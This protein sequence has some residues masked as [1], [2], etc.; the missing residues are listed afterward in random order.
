VTP[1]F[2]RFGFACLIIGIAIGAALN[3]LGDWIMR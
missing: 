1:D 2:R 3:E